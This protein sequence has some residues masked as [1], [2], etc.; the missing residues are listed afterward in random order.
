[1]APFQVWLVTTMRGIKIVSPF[2]HAPYG[3]ATCETLHFIGLSLLIGMIG[4]FDLRLLGVARR[5]PIAAL[6]KLIPWGIA[7]YVINVTTGVMFLITEPEQ[8]IFNPSF[9][10]KLLFMALA[11]VNVA[12]FYLTLFGTVRALGP[13]AD[14]PRAAKIVAGVSL[15]S[16]TAV[17]V[18]GRMLAFTRPFNCGPAGAGFLATCFPHG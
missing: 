5:V 9:H 3:W 17:I 4:T 18:C 2:M 13:G 12:A 16:W 8:Y 7:G 10:F 15:T 1:M 6:H 11:G 14:A